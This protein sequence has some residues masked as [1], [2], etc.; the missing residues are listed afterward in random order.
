MSTVL[1]PLLDHPDNAGPDLTPAPRTPLLPRIEH[2]QRLTLVLR[3][4]VDKNVDLVFL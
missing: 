4:C 3:V 1:E 2:I